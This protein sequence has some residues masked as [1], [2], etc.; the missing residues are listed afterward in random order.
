MGN[1]ILRY[2]LKKVEPQKIGLYF[3]IEEIAL[4]PVAFGPFGLYAGFNFHIFRLAF[5]KGDS[6]LRRADS[7]VLEQVM[8]FDLLV[9][10]IGNSVF[11]SV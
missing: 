3:N 5:I 8:R 11:Q 9:K 4:M 10:S 7:V 1:V 6:K 2:L